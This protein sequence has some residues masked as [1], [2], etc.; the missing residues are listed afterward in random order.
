MAANKLVSINQYA[1]SKTNDIKSRMVI[2]YS[3]AYG[4]LY[5]IA[6][7]VKKDG[8]KPAGKLTIRESI[9][10][11]VLAQIPTVARRIMHNQ[12]KFDAHC[13]VWQYNAEHDYFELLITQAFLDAFS[14]RMDETEVVPVFYSL[15]KREVVNDGLFLERQNVPVVT[16][17]E[18]Q[19]T[20]DGV[21]PFAQAWSRFW[22][23]TDNSK[24]ENTFFMLSCF[25]SPGPLIAHQLLVMA[26]F[27]LR[28]HHPIPWIVMSDDDIVGCRTLN[29][30]FDAQKEAFV[31]P[32]CS[33]TLHSEMFLLQ[34][35]VE[36]RNA[37]EQKRIGYKP[38]IY[39]AARPSNARDIRAAKGNNPFSQT[40]RADSF[41]LISYESAVSK[42][43][44][45]NRAVMRLAVTKPD[46]L[47]RAFEDDTRIPW[48]DGKDEPMQR[49]LAFV[50]NQS[51]DYLLHLMTAY[52]TDGIIRTWAARGMI[53]EKTEAKGN[54]RNLPVLD[55][56]HVNEIIAIDRLTALTFDPFE[57]LC[58]DVAA[59]DQPDG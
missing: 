26:W 9:E 57:T 13:A 32:D 52:Y 39:A 34:Q 1:V 56:Y 42:I 5:R 49:T 10:D 11:V 12:D 51:E 20:T 58:P 45:V 36:I 28:T 44:F 16:L 25:Q 53:L 50:L 17:V 46:V 7:H 47:Q 18:A 37:V 48:K 54:T 4:D 21:V 31:A 29:G 35:L 41:L 8:V 55:D 3:D 43:P 38:Q 40:T 15:Y 2:K 33:K 59:E 14:A 30:Q 23:D 19:P 27:L 6:V 24:P 22:S